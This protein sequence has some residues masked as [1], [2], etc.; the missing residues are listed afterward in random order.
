MAPRF[1]NPK[2]YANHLDE[3]LIGRIKHLG[4]IHS[5]LDPDW[6]DLGRLK[7]AG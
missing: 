5:M 4:S 3:D 2:R 7:F 1:G 6:I